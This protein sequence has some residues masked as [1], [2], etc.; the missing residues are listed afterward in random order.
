MNESFKKLKEDIVLA[1]QDLKFGHQIYIVASEE[2]FLK[3]ATSFI[4][5]DGLNV[6][7]AYIPQAEMAD[8]GFKL[9]G[10]KAIQNQVS[11]FAALRGYDTYL[12]TVADANNIGTIPCVPYFCFVQNNHYYKAYMVSSPNMTG[13]KVRVELD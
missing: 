6:Y 11:N 3:L 8:S 9:Y 12:L 2:V 1:Y 7:S 4:T 13:T 5:H 10:D